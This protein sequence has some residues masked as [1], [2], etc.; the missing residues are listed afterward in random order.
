[1][2]IEMGN[3]RRNIWTDGRKISGEEGDKEVKVIEHFGK[4]KQISI[5]KMLIGKVQ[6]IE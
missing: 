3:G 1:M 6:K 5:T 4:A 2:Q